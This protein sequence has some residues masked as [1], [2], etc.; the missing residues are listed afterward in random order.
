MNDFQHFF[1]DKSNIE[2]YCFR[3][4][5]GLWGGDY[6]LQIISKILHLE[7]F[8]LE[9]HKDDKNEYLLK[10]YAYYPN[11]G[12]SK[13]VYLLYCGLVDLAVNKN[14]YEI[15]VPISEFNEEP[16]IPSDFFANSTYKSNYNPKIIKKKI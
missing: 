1:D 9:I 13:K 11:H 16:L 5:T 14:H 15:L 6:E 3:I 10:N 4:N 2:D 8:V 7:I 12:N